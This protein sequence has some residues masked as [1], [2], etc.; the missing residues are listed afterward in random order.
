M[1]NIKIKNV[2]N[3]LSNLLKDDSSLAWSWHCNIAMLAVDS[4][5]DHK[6]ANIRTAEFMKRLFDV[7]TSQS[8][9]YKS[10]MS[11]HHENNLD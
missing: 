10:I 2:V 5:A 1:S 9:E 11:R 6:E 3:N 8:K 7:D 4:G